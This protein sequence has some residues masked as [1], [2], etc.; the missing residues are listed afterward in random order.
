MKA[1][2]LDWTDLH[3]GL[4]IWEEWICGTGTLRSVVAQ[5]NGDLGILRRGKVTI[6]IRRRDKDFRYWD[7]EPTEAQ[8]EAAPWA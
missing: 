7:A 3:E 5:I 4:V 1:R 8:R 6:L 2:L